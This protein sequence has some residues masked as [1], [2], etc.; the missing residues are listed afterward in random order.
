MAKMYRAPLLFFC[1]MS[2]GKAATDLQSVCLLVHCH[3]ALHR[4]DHAHL[5]HDSYSYHSRR[6][7]WF[8]IPRAS[9]LRLHYQC[10]AVERRVEVVEL[11]VRPGLTEHH[12]RILRNLRHVAVGCLLMRRYPLV[13]LR[14]DWSC[15][16]RWCSHCYTTYSFEIRSMPEHCRNPS[17]ELASL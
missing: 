6:Y 16:C 14:S 12:R 5:C 9:I 2:N 8:S 13:N 10:L 3:A 7:P 11:R 1:F 15:S 4:F 17:P